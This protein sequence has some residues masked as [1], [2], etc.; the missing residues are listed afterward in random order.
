[1]WEHVG[2]QGTFLAGAVFTIVASG[3]LAVA[4]RIVPDVGGSAKTG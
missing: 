2:P 3:G 1:L 4:R